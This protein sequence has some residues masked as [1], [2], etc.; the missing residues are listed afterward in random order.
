MLYSYLMTIE[1]TVEI[2]ASRRVTFDLPLSFP[3]GTA[4]VA[5]VVFP[6]APPDPPRTLKHTNIIK[7][8][9]VYQIK[10]SFLANEKNQ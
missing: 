1:Q 10:N 7:S 4:K 9:E 8:P 6:E 5:L 3:I 2:P